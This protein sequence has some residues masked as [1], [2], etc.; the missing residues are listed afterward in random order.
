MNH[1]ERHE[2]HEDTCEQH[3]VT[4][5]NCGKSWCELA[6][7]APAALCHWCH[8]RGYSDAELEAA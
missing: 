1:R 6:D 3:R 8:G 2:L 4:C 7:P 5:G